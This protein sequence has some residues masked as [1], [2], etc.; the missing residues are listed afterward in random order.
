[1]PSTAQA[2]QDI[3]ADIDVRAN[4]LRVSEKTRPYYVILQIIAASLVI[5]A[6]SFNEDDDD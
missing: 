5:L 4:E 2:L 3:A 6:T 1:M